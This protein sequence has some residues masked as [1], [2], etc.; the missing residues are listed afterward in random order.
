MGFDHIKRNRRVNEKSES[1]CYGVFFF[2]LPPLFPLR[3]PT[4]LRAAAAAAA[5]TSAARTALAV[6]W[7]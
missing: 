1:H 5:V 2:L 7:R 4:L 3:P 6:I